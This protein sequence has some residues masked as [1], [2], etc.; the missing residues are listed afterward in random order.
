MPQLRVDWIFIHII[1]SCTYII[2]P[3]SALK[4]PIHVYVHGTLT[5]ELIRVVQSAH[6]TFTTCQ[7]QPYDSL[8]I[9]T[10][11]VAHLIQNASRF[12]FDLR[13]KLQFQSNQLHAIR[14]VTLTGASSLTFTV[15]GS[16][17]PFVSMFN[18]NKKNSNL[19]L[20]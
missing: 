4:L 8:Q 5:N 14:P 16:I 7:T 17:L 20:N 1:H 19:A 9:E 18:C 10:H 6:I 12:Y 15:Q 3:V 11:F 2:L 13:L